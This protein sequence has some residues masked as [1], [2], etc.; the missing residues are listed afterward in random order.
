MTNQIKPSSLFIV[1]PFCQI[2]NLI[3]TNYGSDVFLMSAPAGVVHLDDEQATELKSFIIRQSVQNIY[4]VNDIGCNFL[5]DT[6]LQKSQ[7]GLHCESVLK[8]LSQQIT[9]D[10]SMSMDQKCEVL[11]RNNMSKQIL[12]LKNNDI[13][14]LQDVFLGIKVETLVTDKKLS[15]IKTC[16]KTYE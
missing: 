10:S 4:L 5:V 9:V 3:K 7:F 2:D 11:A 1:C 16:G 6:I 14:N 12:S 13:L 8:E 15:K